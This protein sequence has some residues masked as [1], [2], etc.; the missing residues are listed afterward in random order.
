[1]SDHVTGHVTGLRGC[2]PPLSGPAVSRNLVFESLP[3]FVGPEKGE[4]LD[5]SLS[6]ITEISMQY[7]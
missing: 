7:A 3:F 4:Y 2:V 1:M 5:F 6:L